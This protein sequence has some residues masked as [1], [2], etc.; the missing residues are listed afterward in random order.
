MGRMKSRQTRFD[1]EAYAL[2]L[3][4]LREEQRLAFVRVDRAY[5]SWKANMALDDLDAARA[6]EAAA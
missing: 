3:A 2:R 1:R 5:R 4:E 6:E